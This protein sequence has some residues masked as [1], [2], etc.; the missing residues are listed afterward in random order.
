MDLDSCNFAGSVSSLRTK[1]GHGAS[2]IRSR[3]PTADYRLA[4][5]SLGDRAVDNMKYATY[6]DVA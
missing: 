6:A 3:L 4:S 5:T 2:L 1:R